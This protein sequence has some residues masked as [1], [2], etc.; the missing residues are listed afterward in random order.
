VPNSLLPSVIAD[1]NP[2]HVWRRVDGQ[3]SQD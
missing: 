3:L 2:D 1:G